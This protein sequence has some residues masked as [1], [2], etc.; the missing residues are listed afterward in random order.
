MVGL[1]VTDTGTQAAQFQGAITKVSH[2]RD[3]N[4]FFNALPEANAVN[5][6]GRVSWR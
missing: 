3:K 1:V 5:E 2:E 4:I 6:K